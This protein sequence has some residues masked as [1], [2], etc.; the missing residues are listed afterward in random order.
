MYG[1]LD[2]KTFMNS[3]ELAGDRCLVQENF[4][5]LIQRRMAANDRSEKMAQAEGRPHLSIRSL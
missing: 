1:L 2:Q 4:F 3:A 5:P